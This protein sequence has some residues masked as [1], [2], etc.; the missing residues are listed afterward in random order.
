MKSNVVEFP[1]WGAYIRLPVTATNAEIIPFPR[2]MRADLPKDARAQMAR[3]LRERQIQ[4][5][6]STAWAGQPRLPTREEY[7]SGL[8]DIA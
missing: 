6:M 2:P 4:D 7:G 5:A 1:S 3:D 8:D